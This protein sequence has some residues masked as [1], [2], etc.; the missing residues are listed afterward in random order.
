MDVAMYSRTNAEIY[1]NIEIFV[2]SVTFPNSHQVNT[3]PLTGSNKA[4]TGIHN[5]LRCNSAKTHTCPSYVV[6]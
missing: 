1:R 3:I 5:S 6:N 2:I 4:S